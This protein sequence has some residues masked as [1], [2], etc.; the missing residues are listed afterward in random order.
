MFCPIGL[1]KAKEKTA[2]SCPVAPPLGNASLSFLPQALADPWA[3]KARSWDI[4]ALAEKRAARASLQEASRAPFAEGSLRGAVLR[5]SAPSALHDRRQATR[6]RFK[7]SMS[8]SDEQGS[9]QPRSVLA[10][11]SP[12][13]VATP[14]IV[15]LPKSF[16]R[17][18]PPKLLCVAFTASLW[19]KLQP[20]FPAQ[21]P[22][23]KKPQQE[24]SSS[25][26]RRADLEQPCLPFL[27]GKESCS[28]CQKG[29]SRLPTPRAG[30]LLA[31]YGRPPRP[32]FPS[33]LGQLP[34]GKRRCLVA[35]VRGSARKISWPASLSLPYPRNR[36]QLQEPASQHIAGS[37]CSGA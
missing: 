10:G 29:T 11:A 4:W 5:P 25:C 17:D 3:E 21:Q 2:P 9:E 22:K 24:Q 18:L 1:Q 36:I 23:T 15:A 13:K 16:T 33:K 19:T 12:W 28:L 14:A 20:G 26:P 8:S 34:N 27:S 37:R 7:S 31:A 35:C 32:T 6:T 30:K